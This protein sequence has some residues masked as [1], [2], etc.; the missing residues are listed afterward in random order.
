MKRSVEIRNVMLV[1]TM[2]DLSD[3]INI[4]IGI[5]ILF[6][7]IYAN[8]DYVMPSLCV[9]LPEKGCGLPPVID[10][11]AAIDAAHK[12]KKSFSAGETATLTCK[13]GPKG[14]AVQT[15]LTCMTDGSYE[16]LHFF[17]HKCKYSTLCY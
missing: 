11:N 10:K 15:Q 7:L 13:R 4:K 8:E 6:H 5:R 1:A 16:G 3:D 2:N 17:C 9:F 12:N 14:W